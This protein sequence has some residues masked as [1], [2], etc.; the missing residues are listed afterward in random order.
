VRLAIVGNGA[1]EGELRAEIERRGLSGLVRLFPFRGS[2]QSYLRALDLFVLPSLWESLPISVLEAM[3]C[4]VPVLASRICGTPEAVTDG[5]T[6][7]LVPPADPAALADALGELAAERWKLLELG[8]AGLRT[9][10]ER[11]TL[12]RM[13]RETAAVYEKSL[14]AG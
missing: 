11:F 5:V 12:D 3:A 10:T 14:A 13:V 1:L 7:R 8:A 6:G 4:G 2:V 9:M